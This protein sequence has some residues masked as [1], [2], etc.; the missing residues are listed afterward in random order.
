MRFTTE[1]PKHFR[2]YFIKKF[3]ISQIFI[4][5]FHDMFQVRID[6]FM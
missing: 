2:T 3:E 4:E 6:K 1:K 5:S